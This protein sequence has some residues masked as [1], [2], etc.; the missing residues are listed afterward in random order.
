VVDK[1]EKDVGVI[2]E[3]IVDFQPGRSYE[4][5]IS[6]STLDMSDG[7]RHLGKKTRSSVRWLP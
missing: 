2:N 1:Y 5:I 4:L 7:T 3:D 6:I